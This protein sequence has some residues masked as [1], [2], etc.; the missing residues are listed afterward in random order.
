MTWPP[1]FRA[2]RGIPYALRTRGWRAAQRLH[3]EGDPVSLISGHGPSS[4]DTSPYCVCVLSCS[5]VSDSLRPRGLHPAGLL[6][7]WN[8][9]GK[10]TGAWCH[11]LLQGIF[12][13]QGSNPCL[14]HWQ[15]A[16]LSLAPPGKFPQGPRGSRKA[17]QTIRESC[18]DLPP[19]AKTLLDAKQTCIPTPCSTCIKR[20]Y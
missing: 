1:S 19:P 16:S 15:V 5:A 13:T 9:P 18:S 17:R 7:L 20:G 11:L 6:C 10:D 8:F 3:P 4:A 14:L 12:P 2:S